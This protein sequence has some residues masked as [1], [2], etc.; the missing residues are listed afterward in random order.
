MKRAAI[1]LGLVLLFCAGLFTLGFH[2]GPVTAVLV[3]M[4]LAVAF[5]LG[6][7]H[8]TGSAPVFV[9]AVSFISTAL[10]PLTVLLSMGVYVYGSPS[11]ALAAMVPVLV[12]SGPLWGGEFLI[13]TAAA[14]AAVRI[15]SRFIPDRP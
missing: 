12:K 14:I 15:H 2:G 7:V 13:P 5:A 10:F 1:R 3:H 8:L 6:T 4:G 9:P 11:A